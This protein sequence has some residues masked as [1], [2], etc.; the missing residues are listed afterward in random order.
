MERVF[1]IADEDME[2]T[3]D[4]KDL[5]RAFLRFELSLPWSKR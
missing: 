4:E 1:A 5:G 3:N 2:R